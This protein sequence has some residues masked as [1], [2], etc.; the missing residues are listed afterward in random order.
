M[1]LGS[2]V[3]KKLTEVNTVLIK[4]SEVCWAVLATD[5]DSEICRD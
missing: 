5:A 3:D 2:E 4:E 1:N